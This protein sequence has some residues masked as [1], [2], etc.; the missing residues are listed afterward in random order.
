M[1]KNIPGAM[2]GF[3][4]VYIEGKYIY[5]CNNQGCGSFG[6]SFTCHRI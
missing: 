3:T 5:G 2:I 6:R 4:P 1:C